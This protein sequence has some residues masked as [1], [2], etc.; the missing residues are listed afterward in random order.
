MDIFKLK[1]RFMKKWGLKNCDWCENLRTLGKNNTSS[2]LPKLEYKCF[3]NEKNPLVPCF[4][5]KTSYCLLGVVVSAL[6][7]SGL[8]VLQSGVWFDII[9][10]IK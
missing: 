10:L 2:C 7:V 3:S 8:G 4:W 1:L 6:I 5:T 9:I